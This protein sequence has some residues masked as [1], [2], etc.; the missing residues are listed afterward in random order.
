MHE[1]ISPIAH[2]AQD[3]PPPF[4]IVD[5]NI[6]CPEQPMLHEI[7]RD[8][9]EAWQRLSSGHSRH[10]WLRVGKACQLLR[11]EAMRSAHTNKPEGRRYNQEYSDL[12]KANG[13]DGIDK[14]T[15]SRLF[16]ILDNIAEI[17]KWLATV[18]ANKK[19]HLNHP[20]S[21]W[22]AYERTV[23]KKP[24]DSTPRMPS[25]AEKTRLAL[26]ESQEESAKLKRE[27]ELGSPFTRHDTARAIAGVVFR[28]T[29]SPS[30]AREVA[31]EL[32][33][34]ARSADVQ[35]EVPKVPA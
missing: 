15:R 35:A 3:S 23:V 33:R 22:R 14:A 25:H 29:V 12:L 27:L 26:I 6:G 1:I 7:I 9:Q 18:P 21:I 32:N 31:R 4:A 2:C 17:E 5:L 11:T 20:N 13:L 24:D 28:I 10:D 16:A 19:L 34:L 8:G 30:K